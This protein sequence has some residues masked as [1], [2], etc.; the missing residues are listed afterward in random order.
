MS[1]SLQLSMGTLSK[2]ARLSE[3]RFHRN[4][5]HPNGDAV[6][7]TAFKPDCDNIWFDLNILKVGREVPPIASVAFS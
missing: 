4:S 1:A 5:F 6:S 7:I 2:S 3:P